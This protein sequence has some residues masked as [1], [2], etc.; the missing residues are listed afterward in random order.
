MAWLS[1]N[2]TRRPHF[3][4]SLNVP[5]LNPDFH[6][7]C[8]ANIGSVISWQNM[9]ADGYQLPFFQ[10]ANT[11]ASTLDTLAATEESHL[12][13]YGSREFMGHAQPQ[14]QP[15]T[16]RV[17]KGPPE[18]LSVTGL[19]RSATNCHALGWKFGEQGNVNRVQLGAVPCLCPAKYAKYLLSLSGTINFCQ[20]SE[21]GNFRMGGR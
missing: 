12:I 4:V 9:T 21:M 2:K 19:T 11:I 6:A 7:E 18:L 5:L 10:P 15:T 14:M 8:R 17:T 3:D 16:V 13:I 20:K 1:R